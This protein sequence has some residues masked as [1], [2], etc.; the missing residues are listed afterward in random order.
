MELHACHLAAARPRQW[1]YGGERGSLRPS[2]LSW[3]IPRVPDA[4][5]SRAIP[6]ATHRQQILEPLPR[7]FESSKS[8]KH[9]P[10][11]L[12]RGIGVVPGRDA[13][14]GSGLAQRYSS[15]RQAVYTDIVH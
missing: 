12:H 8:W 13:T 9:S 14:L 11:A 6:N 2:D 7:M 5:R 15:G 4:M 1:R 10:R 3:G